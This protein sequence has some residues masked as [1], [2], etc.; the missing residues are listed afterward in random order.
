MNL[1]TIKSVCADTGVPLEEG[2]CEGP[3]TCIIFLGMELNSITKIIR[4]P[5]DKL[6]KIETVA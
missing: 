3:T 2:K 1:V 6:K 5:D 4:L